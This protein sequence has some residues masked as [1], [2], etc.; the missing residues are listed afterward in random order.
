MRRS[1]PPFGAQDHGF[2]GVLRVG[3][4]SSAGRTDGHR[5]ASKRGE[6]VVRG[7]GDAQVGEDIVADGGTVARDARDSG[8]GVQERARRQGGR[9]GEEHDAHAGAALRE[10]I[11]D[12]CRDNRCLQVAVEAEDEDGHALE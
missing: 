2:G 11:S 3:A 8:R 7:R 1:A 9:H 5:A 4:G 6:R 10:S 12:F